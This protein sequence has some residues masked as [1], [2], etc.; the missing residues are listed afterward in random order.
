MV[1]PA[2]SRNVDDTAI[3]L[4]EAGLIILGA[5]KFTEVEP[6]SQNTKTKD[7]N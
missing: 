5:L 1:R 6:S 4:D 2:A 3:L 7:G